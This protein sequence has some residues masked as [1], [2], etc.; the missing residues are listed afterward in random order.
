MT[1]SSARP[2]GPR[3]GSFTSIR[4][5]PP[6]RAHRASSAERTLTSN[7]EGFWP[8][9]FLDQLRVKVVRES[10]TEKTNLA[11]TLVKRKFPRLI[12]DEPV[13]TF[14][15]KPARIIVMARL[16]GCKSVRLQIVF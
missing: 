11:R 5:A 15:L 2:S 13:Q 8:T 7:L 1:R 3:R 9:L 4:A 16:V 6:R 10:Y 14:F 12:Q